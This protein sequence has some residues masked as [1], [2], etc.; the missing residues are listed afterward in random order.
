MY[1]FG[2][3]HVVCNKTLLN[4]AYRSIISRRRSRLII[5]EKIKSEE[6]SGGEK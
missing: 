1:K 5:M 2:S 4:N 6:D 3:S